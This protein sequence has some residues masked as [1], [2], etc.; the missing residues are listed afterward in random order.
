[1]TASQQSQKKYPELVFGIVGPIGV[2]IDAISESLSTALR[3]VE[4]TPKTVHLTNEMLRADRYQLQKFPVTKPCSSDFYSEV[5]YKINYA[6]SLCKEFS[7]PAT[8]ARI[9]LR[10]IGDLREQL[11]GDRTFIPESPIAYIVRQLKR[12]DEAT[13][14]RQVYGRQFILISAYGPVGKRQQL[15][16]KRLEL[17]LNPDAAHHEIV[18]KATQLIDTDANEAGEDLG[19]NV[20]ETFHMADVFIDGL[21]RAEMDKKLTRHYRPHR[22]IKRH[23][24]CYNRRVVTPRHYGPPIVRYVRVCR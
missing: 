2:D 13:L 3:A 1:M 7:D 22:H 10:A 17:S 8:M 12:P 5:T 19:Q 14:L 24:H 15:L 18:M 21:A 6:N 16:V 23:R 9:A 11:S 4:Y 20:R